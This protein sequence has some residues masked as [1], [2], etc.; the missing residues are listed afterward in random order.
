MKFLKANLSTVLCMALFAA[1]F[2]VGDASAQSVMVTAQQKAANAFQSVK[3]IMYV[4]GAF[5]LVGVAFGAITGKIKWTWFAGLGVG[6]AILAAAGSIV[7][8][9]TGESPSGVTDTFSPAG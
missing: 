8:Y 2:V 5:G 6:L 7:N 3:T 1:M 4:V 9:A